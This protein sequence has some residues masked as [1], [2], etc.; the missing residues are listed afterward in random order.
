MCD[1]LSMS[2]F[3]FFRSRIIIFIFFFF[4]FF[5]PFF[6]RYNFPIRPFKMGGSEFSLSMYLFSFCPSRPKCRNNKLFSSFSFFDTFVCVCVCVC[7]NVCVRM[8][9]SVHARANSRVVGG[10]GDNN[11]QKSKKRK[12]REK[13]PK[14]YLA[15][16]LCSWQP[17]I[18]LCM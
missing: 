2:M 10:G 5:S 13:K 16:N 18:L 7:M 11:I 8:R 14:T 6:S 4:C 3:I 12:K 17:F 1:S 9:V 15:R